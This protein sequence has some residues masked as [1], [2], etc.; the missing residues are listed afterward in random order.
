MQRTDS[1]EAP[2]LAVMK[3]TAVVKGLRIAYED[4]GH[5]LPA[6]VL[7]HG[8]FGNRSHYAIQIRHLAQRHRVLALDLRG[9]GESD[10]PQ[11]GFRQRDYAEDVVA[12]CEAAGLDRYVLC[13]H[14]MPVALMAASLKPD[15]VAGVALLDG[16]ILFPDSLRSQVL[17]NLVP[18]LEGD[19]CTEAMQGYLVG[20]GIG[21]YDSAELKARVLAEIAAVPT[22]I[23]A[24]LMRDVM[25]LDFS[26]FLTGSYPLLYVHARV[27]ADLTR[28]RELRPDVLLGTVVGAGHWMMLEVPDQVNA[29]LDRF[30][31]I[32]DS[33]A[34]GGD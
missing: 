2:G 25:T 1:Q 9:H 23:A 22:R 11:D 16:T 17:A 31:Q 6:V 13:G 30:L 28:L 29:M 14:S 8:A 27:P 21:P 3:R 34:P 32:V 24:P 19:G 4:I 26:Q 10:V 20:R 33:R 5:G 7:I 12:V 18:V 15:R